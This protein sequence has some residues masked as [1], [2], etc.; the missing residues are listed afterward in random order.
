MGMRG[1][2]DNREI[3]R[4]HDA[5]P[6]HF[7]QSGNLA[8]HTTLS[9]TAAPRQ[10]TGYS[11]SRIIVLDASVSLSSYKRLITLQLTAD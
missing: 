11:R 9:H 1:D 4:D 5:T 10:H 7:N 8:Q 6:G 3:T 2:T